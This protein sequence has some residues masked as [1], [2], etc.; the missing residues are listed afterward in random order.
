M[1]RKRCVL[2]FFYIKTGNGPKC[3]DKI[4]NCNAYGADV[5]TQ[6]QY[7]AWATSNCKSFCQLCKYFDEKRMRSFSRTT[8]IPKFASMQENVR[9]I[10]NLIAFTCCYALN[11]VQ[12]N[13]F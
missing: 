12:F 6:P 2:V 11:E 5:C 13:K 8:R 9:K 7:S 10:N 3:V 4:S 1:A